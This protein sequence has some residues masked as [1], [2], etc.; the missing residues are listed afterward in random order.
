MHK[1]RILIA[2]ITL[3]FVTL[4][5]MSVTE[6][7]MEKARTIAAK[8]YLRFANNGSGYLDEIDASTISEL[9]S[10]LKPKEKEN[11]KAFLA[12][13]IPSDYTSWDKAKL[14]EF[15][16]ATAFSSPNLSAEGKGARSRVKSILSNLNIG[17]KEK[18]TT[19][20][21]E[22]KS[23]AES[24]ANSQEETSENV[25][26]TPTSESVSDQKIDESEN[27]TADQD[28]I[29]ADGEDKKPKQESGNTLLYI[30][31][32]IALIAAV[33]MLAMFAVKMMKNQP[34]EQSATHGNNNNN[35][36]PNAD[37]AKNIQR[38]EAATR[39][40]RNL[41]EQLDMT[42]SKNA[43]LS[44]QNAQ[45]NSQVA[46]LNNQLSQLSARLR[47]IQ[48]E[49]NRRINEE[50]MVS[51]PYEPTIR[52]EYAPTSEQPIASREH[53]SFQTH[54]SAPSKN[55]TTIYLG[56]VN[57]DGIFVRADYRLAPGSSVFRL[58][59]RDGL[60]GTFFVVDDP[61][62]IDLALSDPGRYLANGCSSI[63]DLYDTDDVKHIITENAG[64][65]IIED[66]RWKVLRRTRISYQR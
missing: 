35:Y 27:I 37:N 13:S 55:P 60:V 5:A 44:A 21:N 40:I 7:E 17:E 6:K 66:G 14:T 51:Q 29:Q 12:I 47:Q 23:D 56:R 1:F 65:A 4:P 10:K 28:A 53:Q 52:S 30:I 61:A 8:T 20:K 42:T 16:G 49:T 43:Q 9:Q 58:E 2:L 46:Q 3:T 25:A 33:V 54:E 19:T 50:Q 48:D 15:W 34:N 59:S 18:E 22:T 41:R 26:A 36:Q 31:L 24:T 57:K 64:T 63:D 62:V 11:L 38:L 32:L 39:E 45:L